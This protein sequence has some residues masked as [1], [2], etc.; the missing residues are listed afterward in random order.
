VSD[1]Q[2]NQALA[3][4][5]RLR[6]ELQAAKE[7]VAIVGMACRFPGAESPEAF[8]ALLRDGVDAICEVPADRW[9][10]DTLY[11]PDPQEPGKISTR[12]GGLLEQVDRFDAEFFGISPR[13]A[14]SLDPQQRLLL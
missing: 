9:D 11:D 13:E 4:L 6:A 7:A 12:W 10:V 1:E 2:L 8:W 14:A 3:A 5:Q